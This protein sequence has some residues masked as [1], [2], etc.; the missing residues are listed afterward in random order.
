MVGVERANIRHR[1]ESATIPPE[2]CAQGCFSVEIAIRRSLCRQLFQT[3]GHVPFRQGKF[4]D[5]GDAY[6]PVLFQ[7]VPRAF[8]IHILLG[9]K[10]RADPIKCRGTSLYVLA[11]AS[12]ISSF[13]VPTDWAIHTYA[14]P[15]S[16]RIL[17]L[18][19]DKQVGGGDEPPPVL[20]LPFV[21]D[22]RALVSMRP[23][24][25]PWLRGPCRRRQSP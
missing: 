8:Y 12:L 18:R 15:A 1:E 17:S 4:P 6:E 3:R 14:L 16:C 9:R 20:S 10:L 21:T 13:Q 23:C 2:L 19:V 5:G 11:E 7:F 22:D 25:E 24:R